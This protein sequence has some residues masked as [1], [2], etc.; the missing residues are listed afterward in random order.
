MNPRERYY[1]MALAQVEPAAI[2]PAIEQLPLGEIGFFAIAS[3]WLLQY[4]LKHANQQSTDSWAMLSRMVE[5]QQ[6]TNETLAKTNREL[7]IRI[8]RIHE[9]LERMERVILDGHNRGPK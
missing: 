6:Q 5:S 4:F 3:L 1:S 7:V 2:A 9:R 8:S